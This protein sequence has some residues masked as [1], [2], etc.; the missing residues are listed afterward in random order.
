MLLPFSHQGVSDS[1]RPHGLQHTRLCR[2]SPSPGV[3]SN[4]CPL[5]RWCHPTVSSSVVPFSSCLQSF[6]GSG[7]FPVSQLFT[8]GG[9]NIEASASASV[10]PVN[11]QGW[12]PLGLT[13]LILQSKSLLQHH[14]LKASIIWHSAFFMVQLSHLYMTTEKTIAL[15]IWTFVGK[16][17]SLLFNT[18]SRF[19]TAFLLLIS[20]LQ[21]PFAV[22][23]EP[24]KIKSV[25]AS[26]FSPSICYEAMG[27]DTMILVFWMVSF[28]S[29][30]SPSSF[31]FINKLF[32]KVAQSYPTLCDP[33]DYTVHG[34]LQVKIWSG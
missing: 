22:I 4:S 19:V 31:T 5:S 23:L 30:F 1:L 34:I 27:L 17:M 16:V 3:R 2:P 8:S 29:A 6:P 26:T 24:E 13:V 7:S 15:T 33:L 10:L 14:R 20:W 32:V 25:T 28:K 12:F 21:S 11:I 9:R 18:L